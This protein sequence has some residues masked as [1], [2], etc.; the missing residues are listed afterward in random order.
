LASFTTGYKLPRNWEVSARH[1]FAAATPFVPTD[2]PQTAQ[3]YPKIVLDYDRLGSQ[4]L[5]PFNKIIKGLDNDELDQKIGF[6]AEELRAEVELVKGASHAFDLE[7]YRQGELTPVFF[8]T[9]LSNFGIKE[10]LDTF[11]ECAPSPT[12]RVTDMREVRAEEEL[13]TGFVFKIQANMDPNHRDRIAFMRV[14]SGQY[15]KGMKMRHN[16]IGKEIKI[17]DAVTFLAGDRSQ[18]ESA[19]SG[20]I[21][22]LHNHGTIQIGDTFTEGEELE[23]QGIPHFA[24]ELF[25]RIRLQDPLKVKQLQKGLTQLSEEGST[26][27]FMPL[28]NNDLIVGAVGALQFEVVAFRLKDE[29]KVDCQYEPINVQLA[30]WV[31]STNRV[32]LDEFRKKAHDNLAVDGGGYLTYLAPTRVN[33]ALME[34]RWPDIEFRATRE[35]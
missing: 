13:L 6:L 9:A 7:K 18:A 8:G 5:D 34:E 33:L 21:I 22:G 2:I 15:S 27:L 23:F 28:R 10:M 20:D 35:H 24:P 4:K 29:Y 12:P 17:A 16:R 11:T 25:K 32:K 19:V 3:L 31:D 1:R 14:C 30:R 26:Q